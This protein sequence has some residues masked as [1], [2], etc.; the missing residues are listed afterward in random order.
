MSDEKEA[1]FDMCVQYCT[2]TTENSDGL[3][4]A[5]DKFYNRFMSAGERAFKILGIKNGEIVGDVAKRLGYKDWM[6]EY[7]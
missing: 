5:K 2:I 1:L 3:C 6:C 4:S 7:D